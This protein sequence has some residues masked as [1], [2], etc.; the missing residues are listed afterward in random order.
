MLEKRLKEWAKKVLASYHDDRPE[1]EIIV[2]THRMVV[3]VDKIIAEEFGY[4]R[5]LS[6]SAVTAEQTYLEL[7]EKLYEDVKSD[8][9][10]SSDVRTE[11][12]ETLASLRDLLWDYSA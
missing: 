9:G 6:E 5:V 3:E 12:E 7:I 2:N 10:I 11:V 8:A 1:N 4:D